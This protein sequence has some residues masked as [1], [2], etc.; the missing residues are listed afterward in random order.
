MKIEISESLNGRGWRWV[1]VGDKGYILL[2]G[3]WCS[4]R[5]EAVNAGKAFVHV[6]SKLKVE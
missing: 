5:A 6:V 4:S 3:D 2:G 1:L